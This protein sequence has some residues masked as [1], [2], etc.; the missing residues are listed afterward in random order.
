MIRH[1]LSWLGRLALLALLCLLL[2][3]A[4]AFAAGTVLAP[5]PQVWVVLL[6]ALTPLAVYVLNHAAPWV[7]E[8]AKAIVLAVVAGVVAAIYTAIE[9]SIFGF[10]S[11]TLQLVLS[12][13][14]SAFG[15]HLLVYKPSGISVKLGGGS[16]APAARGV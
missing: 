16:N 5:V 9:T 15:A 4:L 7:S 3:P 11:A 10:N 8:P 2:L 12:A 1:P 6:G 14:V 13:I